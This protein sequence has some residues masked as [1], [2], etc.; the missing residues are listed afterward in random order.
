MKN[1]HEC[2]IIVC[3]FRGTNLQCIFPAE[4]L[5]AVV[6]REGLDRQMDPLVALQVV[7]AIERLRAL[8]ALEGPLM[9][10]RRSAGSVVSLAAEDAWQVVVT[11]LMRVQVVPVHCV[12]A[13]QERPAAATHVTAR[14]TAW[15]AA[16]TAILHTHI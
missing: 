4:A 16:T 11:D 15:A 5:V 1:I 10:S 9:D 6:A 13:V 7:V 12:V 8:V 14:R 2:K 3:A